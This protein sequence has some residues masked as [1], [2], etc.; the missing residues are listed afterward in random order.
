MADE[1]R[2]EAVVEQT[3]LAKHSPNKAVKAIFS[4]SLKSVGNYI[5]KDIVVPAVKNLLDDTISKGSHALI[6]GNQSSSGRSRSREESVSYTPYER[7]YQSSSS[8]ISSTS[9]LA[10]KRAA[11]VYD[12]VDVEFA[13]MGKAQKVLDS[14]RATLNRYKACSVRDMYDLADTRDEN[15]K[16]VGGPQDVKYGWLSLSEDESKVVQY[17][18]KWD[19]DLPKAVPLDE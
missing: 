6:W 18:G 16:P 10:K 5:L 14:M 2:Q 12:Y 15:G 11:S 1:K 13:S 9:S 17:G 3:S 4:D 19:L 8:S 7:K